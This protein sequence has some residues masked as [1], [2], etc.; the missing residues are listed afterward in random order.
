MDVLLVR[1]TTPFGTNLSLYRR[2]SPGFLDVRTYSVAAPGALGFRRRT[3]PRAP[4]LPARN[5]AAARPGRRRAS[6]GVA[7]RT[8]GQGSALQ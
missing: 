5:P 8:C 1:V 7:T 4:S 6:Q 2:D 3:G